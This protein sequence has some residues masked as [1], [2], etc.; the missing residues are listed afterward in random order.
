MRKRWRIVAGVNLKHTMTNTTEMTFNSSRF[1]CAQGYLW[2][3]PFYGDRVFVARFKYGTTRDAAGFQK[4][5]CE[6]FTVEEYFGRYNAGEAPARILESKGYL[7][8]TIRRA[9]RKYGYPETIEGKK[10]YI[11]AVV[12]NT[13]PMPCV[14]QDLPPGVFLLRDPAV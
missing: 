13:L 11:N 7:S 4:F 6:N 5:L 9:L 14:K 10:A 12:T 8:T 2:Y 1:S 3:H